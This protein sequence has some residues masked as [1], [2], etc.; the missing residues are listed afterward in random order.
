[1]NETESHNCPH[2]NVQAYVVVETMR[3]AVDNN[4]KY[5]VSWYHCPKCER[6][7][8]LL[9]YGREILDSNMRWDSIEQ[10]MPERMIVPPAQTR[11]VPVEVPEGLRS[12][13][14]E[15]SMV[16][17]ISPKASAA[18]SRRC[19]QNTIRNTKGIKE[20]TLYDEVKKVIDDGLVSSGLAENLD[21]VRMHGNFAAHP[22][23]NVTTGE[24]IDVAPDE[25]AWNLELLDGLFDEWF[26]IPEKN[27]LRK[28]RLEEKSVEAGK[29]PIS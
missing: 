5:F 14:I 23:Q 13:Y 21:A 24:I 15:A 29:S 2:C 19:L 3:I 17:A 7:V 26:V 25:A 16:L 18:L 22:M 27:R 8:I 12:D 4:Q 20:R 6:L 10:V 11:H 28:A 9:R 1:M